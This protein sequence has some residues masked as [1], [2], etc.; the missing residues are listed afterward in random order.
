MLRILAEQ[1]GWTAP[2]GMASPKIDSKIGGVQ[3]GAQSYS[4]RDRPMDKA[5]EAYKK[6]IDLYP[7]HAAARHNL[8]LLYG[9]FTGQHRGQP[10]KSEAEFRAFIEAK[11]KPLL[12]SF[13]IADVESLFTSPRDK[14]PYVV[15]Y[16]VVTGPPGPAGQPVIAYEQEGVGGKRF[17][18]S[19]LGAVDEIDEEV[20]GWL[21]RRRD[22]VMAGRSSIR[23]GHVDFFATP[24]ATR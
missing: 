3:L 20:V 16:G 13:G 24:T 6:A 11:G 10:P 22:L 14:K 1:R 19:S 9:Q 18:A 21:T 7:D 8:A 2:R 12:A 4:F 5:I 23:V 15:R 17:V